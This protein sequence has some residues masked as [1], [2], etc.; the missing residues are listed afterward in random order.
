MSTVI[1][2]N[3][4]TFKSK[5]LHKLWSLTI[6]TGHEGIIG[7]IY[8]LWRLASHDFLNSEQEH[9]NELREGYDAKTKDASDS[10]CSLLYHAIRL[11]IPEQVY[12]N[13]RY[14]SNVLPNDFVKGI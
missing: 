4:N 1:T 11:G 10:S 8:E 5:E 13:L 2:K 12:F 6:K 14:S 3:C 7:Q 9:W